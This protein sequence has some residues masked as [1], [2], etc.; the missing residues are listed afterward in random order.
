MTAEHC[1]ARVV[2]HSG[3]RL[4][5]GCFGCAKAALVLFTFSTATGTSLRRQAYLAISGLMGPEE[6]AANLDGVAADEAHDAHRARLAKA[7]HARERLLLHRHIE[8]GLQ[9]KHIACCEHSRI[10][11]WQHTGPR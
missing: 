1:L 11:D 6:R 9:Q 2:L 3:S 10:I 5:H 4:Y 8:R 7:M